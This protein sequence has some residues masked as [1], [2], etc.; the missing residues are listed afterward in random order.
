L[1][2]QNVSQQ[3]SD[4]ALVAYQ[5]ARIDG[6]KSAL[7]ILAILVVVALFLAQLIPRN[8][9]GRAPPVSA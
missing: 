2:E 6:L 8:Q 9:P 7:A 5:D 4:A 3:T 1:N